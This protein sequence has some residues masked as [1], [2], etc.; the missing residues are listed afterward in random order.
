[1][2]VK[3]Q[4]RP[5]LRRRKATKGNNILVQ[6]TAFV[7]TILLL[8]TAA[9]PTWALMS[10]AEERVL[11]QKLLKQVLSQ[12]RLVDDP[13]IVDFVRETGESILEVIGRKYF[14]YRF[15]VIKDP[16][17]NAFAMPGGLVFVHS[18]LLE[19]IGSQ[20]ELACVMAHEFAHVQGR[21]VA[22]RMDNMKYVSIGTA[23]MAI[24]G[25]FLGRGELGSAILTG[26]MA[27]NQAIAL[28]YSRADEQEA[29]RRA[30]QWLCKAGWDPR[31]LKTTLEK[32]MKNNWLGSPHIPKYLSTH[33]VP[34]ERLTYL[35]DLWRS[36][37]C[38]LKH[39]EDPFRVERIKVKIKVMSAD[40]AELIARYEQ[41]LK[42][43][44]Q[45]LK[46]LYG[47]ALSL[48]RARRFD[49]AIKTYDKIIAQNPNK[50]IFLRDKAITLFH[51]GRYKE[52]VKILT[53]F[54]KKHPRDITTI[55]FLGRSYLEGGVPE[56][57]IVYFK[58]LL[59]DWEENTPFL[60]QLGRC[61]AGL[62]QEGV[63]H[64]YFYKYYALI[65]KMDAAQY[66]RKRALALLPKTSPI[67]K[68]LKNEKEEA[69]S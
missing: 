67:L 49:K 29:D 18:G 11:G 65:G 10:V 34:E 22:R 35:E 24:A 19:A 28:K 69:K 63:A 56:K 48:D 39:K 44:P 17:L 13:E 60:F 6:I 46:Y 57:A 55:Y 21:H 59:P 4:K 52:A 62:K 40:P 25:L 45:N 20:N 37:P 15:F 66:H 26:S 61:Y 2:R 47:Y 51:M 14:K 38:Y 33:P 27:M 53:A 54:L 43:S 8:T 5:K 7:L 41:L 23:V 1:V 68:K 31:G 36:H 58:R 32:M 12:V 50:D 3:E 16:A 30:F 64:Y 42:K 9:S